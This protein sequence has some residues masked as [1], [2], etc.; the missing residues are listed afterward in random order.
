MSPHLKTGKT[1][2]EGLELDFPVG[3]QTSE[4]KKSFNPSTEDVKMQLDEMNVHFQKGVS[5]LTTRYGKNT[6]TAG[7]EEVDT[8]KFLYMCPVGLLKLNSILVGNLDSAKRKESVMNKSQRAS[9]TKASLNFC[10]CYCCSELAEK[11]SELCPKLP[12]DKVDDLVQHMCG[13]EFINH[14]GIENAYRKAK[15][16]MLRWHSRDL[17]TKNVSKSLLLP[18]VHK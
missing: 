15:N 16:W 4:I 11:L 6:Q 18:R 7:A 1:F 8:K 10:Y 9:I 5:E 14:Q 2:V 3:K 12:K 17:I 13:M